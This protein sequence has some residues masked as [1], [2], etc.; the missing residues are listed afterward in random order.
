MKLGLKTIV[1]ALVV[2]LLCVPAAFAKG[3]GGHGQ[4][5]PSWAGQGKPSW[6]GGGGDHGKANAPG[7]LKKSQRA[8]QQEVTVQQ[9]EPKHDN[10]AW[11]CK[12]ERDNSD[13]A[14]FAEKYGTNENDANAFGMCVS[15]AAQAQGDTADDAAPESCD[16]A[17]DTSEDDTSGDEAT[18]DDGSGDVADDTSG[19]EATSDDG[20]GDVADDGSGDVADDGSGDVADECQ[21]DGSTEEPSADEGDSA[22]DDQ[23]EETDDQGDETEIAALA[24]ALVRFIKL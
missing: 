2:A 22:D 6:A 13:A 15:Q 4:G 12:F 24:R 7:Q 3:P 16:T 19:D 9:D 11:N 23:D 21:G 20:S 8:T 14:T 17:G 5:K 10:P 18:S 1:L